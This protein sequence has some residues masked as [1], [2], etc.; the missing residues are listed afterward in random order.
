[1][2]DLVYT[3]NG[4]TPSACPADIE[5]TEY[6]YLCASF[7]CIYVKVDFHLYHFGCNDLAEKHAQKSP[8]LLR[9]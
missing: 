5:I 3:S 2:I 6:N 1:M 7:F 4:G 9:N 8:I